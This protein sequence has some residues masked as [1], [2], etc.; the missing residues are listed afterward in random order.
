VVG[1]AGIDFMHQFN[2]STKLTNKVIA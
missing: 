1:T 2:S